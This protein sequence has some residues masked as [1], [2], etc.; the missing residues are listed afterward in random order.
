MQLYFIVVMNGEHDKRSR[1]LPAGISP[2]A[3][4]SLHYLKVTQSL[5]S[6]SLKQA[7]EQTHPSQTWHFWQCSE[8]CFI[9]RPMLPSGNSQP[10]GFAGQTLYYLSRNRWFIGN[11]ESA[12]LFLFFFFFLQ[13]SINWGLQ[14]QVEE[15]V[16]PS[17]PSKSLPK[18]NRFTIAL[19]KYPLLA[20]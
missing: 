12:V 16:S 9:Y 14:Q 2:P 19:I 18:L 4:S 6:L 7:C 11:A 15:E 10:F 3:G 5:S 17:G 20:L 1:Y 8:L 13:A